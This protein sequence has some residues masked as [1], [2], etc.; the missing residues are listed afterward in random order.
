MYHHPLGQMG[1]WII[2]SLLFCASV[3]LYIVARA[4]YLL[5]HALVEGFAIVVAALI[6]VLAT[7][8]YQYSRNTTF[9]FLGIPCN[10]AR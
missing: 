7:R 6:Y 9:F 1:V 10:P 3:V 8:T 4:N 2:L 5:F